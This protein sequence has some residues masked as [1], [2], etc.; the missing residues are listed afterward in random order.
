MKTELLDLYVAKYPRMSIAD[1]I[2]NFSDLGIRFT[3][4]QVNA[5]RKRLGLMLPKAN[6]K[7][8][9]EL[10]GLYMV[11]NPQMSSD[12]I[13]ANFKKNGIN[14][15]NQDIYMARKNLGIKPF[16]QS[17]MIRQFAKEH[18][19]LG[20]TALRKMLKNRGHD[21]TYATIST[22]LKYS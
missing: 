5:S 3:V 17:D 6:V 8:K 7:S 18:P 14:V 16:K 12:D 13:K 15:I 1:I 9:A 10:V 20:V 21:L 19:L 11:Q 4:N 22:A 2:A